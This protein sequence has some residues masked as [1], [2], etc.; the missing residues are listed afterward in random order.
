ML[1]AAPHPWAVRPREGGH[2]WG[3]GFGNEEEGLLNFHLKFKKKIEKWKEGRGGGVSWMVEREGGPPLHFYF[4]LK[5]QNAKA[6][7]LI[8]FFFIIIIIRPHPRGGEGG[9]G[10]LRASPSLHPPPVLS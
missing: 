2:G 7:S 5:I 9:R 6:P 4:F 1:L 8:F 3:G 10:P